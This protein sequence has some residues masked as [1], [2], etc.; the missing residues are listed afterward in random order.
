MHD[1]LSEKT[2][3]RQVVEGLQQGEVQLQFEFHTEI[4]LAEIWLSAE[5]DAGDFG[6]W[7]VGVVGSSPACNRMEW[8]EESRHQHRASGV[9]CFRPQANSVEPHRGTRWLV[10]S[11]SSAC[12]DHVHIAALGNAIYWS[13]LLS[14]TFTEKC[15][16]VFSLIRALSLGGG[17]R[18]S[19]IQQLPFGLWEYIMSFTTFSDW[20]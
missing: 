17:P 16:G 6:R 1:W 4:Q 2:T 15:L 18:T 13:P 10:L 8:S 12:F 19:L 3:K 5:D 14:H 7:E 20:A 9:A 11:M